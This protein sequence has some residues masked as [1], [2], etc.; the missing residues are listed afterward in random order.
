MY[1]KTFQKKEIAQKFLVQHNKGHLARESIFSEFNLDH[2]AEAKALFVLFYNAKNFD[3]LYKLACWSR[4]NLNG[5]LFLYSF[6]AALTHREDC[7]SFS[8]PPIYEITPH[9]FFN[10]ETIQKAQDYKVKHSS[11]NTKYPK[12]EDGFEGYTINSNYS[13]YQFNIHPDQSLVNYYLEDVG[14]NAFFY[15]Y[16]LYYPYWLSGKELNS[17]EVFYKR[18]EVFYFHCQESAAR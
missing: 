2:I 16:Y 8:I 14:V 13:G 9:F 10:S 18:G 7:K 6:G 4:Q 17:E 15:Y 12:D 5:R 3:S 1:Q 11:G